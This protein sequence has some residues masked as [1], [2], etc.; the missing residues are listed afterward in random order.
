MAFLGVRA[1]PNS[2]RARGLP[3]PDAA[4]RVELTGPDGDRWTFGPED[5]ADVV[6]GPALDFCLVVTQRRHPADTALVGAE[7]RSRPS[8]C[9]SPRRSPGPPGPGR[10]PG[11]FAEDRPMTQADAGP[12]RQLLGVLRRPPG[13]PRE[14]LDGPDPID[15]LTGDYLAELTML[16][17]WK[18]RQK[19]PTPATRRPSSARWRTCSAPASSGASRWSPT[20]AA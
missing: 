9:R 3:V 7:D 10:Q 14:M 6:R 16:I 20:P 18:A 5:A 19:D 2:Y 8:G 12:H 11:E 17:L 4:I 13:R 15:V 1:V